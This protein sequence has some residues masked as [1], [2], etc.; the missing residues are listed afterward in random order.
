MVQFKELKNNFKPY[1]YNYYNSLKKYY[2][3]QSYKKDVVYL[4]KLNT[5]KY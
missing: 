5:L 3:T 1:V 2:Y 4:Q